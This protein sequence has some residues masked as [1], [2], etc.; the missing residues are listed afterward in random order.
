MRKFCDVFLA[1]LQV[2]AVFQWLVTFTF[3]F[4]SAYPFLHYELLH[5]SHPLRHSRPVLHSSLVQSSRLV[6]CLLCYLLDLLPSFCHLS[7]LASAD[8]SMAPKKNTDKGAPS[9]VM[10]VLKR[11]D[12]FS[13]FCICPFERFDRMFDFFFA[14]MQQSQLV[15]IN[16]LYSIEDKLAW[17]SQRRADPRSFIQQ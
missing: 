2:E 11:W 7:R 17:E 8:V 16:T 14:K 15:V 12:D 3:I 13:Y 10:A 4:S 6:K 5:R 1:R 9:W